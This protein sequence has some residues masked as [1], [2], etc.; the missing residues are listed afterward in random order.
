MGYT[1]GGVSFVG[2]EIIRD[3]AQQHGW[4]PTDHVRGVVA[5]HEI[6]AHQLEFLA[7]QLDHP[8]PGPYPGDN[9]LVVPNTDTDEA[10]AP[11]ATPIFRD[12]SIKMIR[13]LP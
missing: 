13:E 7:T 8:Y 12:E 1:T 2:N 5:L 3:V 10:Q 4:T 9:V 11:N 6:A